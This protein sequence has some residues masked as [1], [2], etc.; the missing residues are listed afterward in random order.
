MSSGP[1]KLLRDSEEKLRQSFYH[2]VRACRL[3]ESRPTDDDLRGDV[4]NA[5]T[6]ATVAAREYDRIYNLARTRPTPAST[7]S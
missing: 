2:Y 6:L 3:S 5:S 1:D 7:K 4:L